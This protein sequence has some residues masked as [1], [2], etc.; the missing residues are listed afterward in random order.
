MVSDHSPCTRELKRL[1]TGDF[2]TA[3]GSIAS[4]QLG[5]RLV[6][7]EARQRGHDVAD[8]ARWM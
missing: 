5:L 8:V 7:T 4:L 2:G 1:D 6:W 3:C